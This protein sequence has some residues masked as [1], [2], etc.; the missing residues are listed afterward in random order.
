MIAILDRTGAFTHY[1]VEMLRTWGVTDVLLVNEVP[2][3]GTAKVFIVPASQQVDAQAVTAFASQ[4]GVVIAI[5]PDEAL[6]TVAGLRLGGARQ[7]PGHVRFSGI[8][9]GGFSGELVPIVSAANVYETEHA[10]PPLAYLCDRAKFGGES[11]AV[12]QRSVGEGSVVTIAFDLPRCVMLLRQGDPARREFVPEGDGC[13]R[14]S[15]MAC[16]KAVGDAGWT[17]YADLLARMLVEI[18]RRQLPGPTPLLWHLPAGAPSLLLYSGD[19]DHAPI[20]DNDEQM[21]TLQSHGGRMDLYII[22]DLTHSTAAD[23]ARYSLHHDLGPHPNLRPLDG[24]PVAERL[25]GLRRQI[26]LFKTTFGLQPLSVRN[27]CTAWAGYM[28][29]VEVLEECG[30]RMEGSYFSSDYM[31]GR[32]YAPY[33]SFGG[34]MP[35]R[36]CRPNG[37]ILN[38]YQQHT[39]WS[40]DVLFAPDAGVYKK[41]TYSYRFSPEVFGVMVDRLLRDAA[42][43]FATPVAVCIH[44]SNRPKFSRPHDLLM[45]QAANRIGMPIW[46][47]TQWCRF[48]MGR[49]QC[50]LTNI[51]WHA[52][53]LEF[54]VTN[55]ADRDD[56]CM[57]IPLHHRAWHMVELLVAGRPVAISPTTVHREQ[58]ALVPMPR[59]ESKVRVV[60]REYQ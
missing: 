41:T 51:R 10:Q 23:V 48:W 60:Y 27:H 5:M 58:V 57:A 55:D 4:G 28:E 29:H 1:L 49:E 18:I 35:M 7:M 43:R 15:H 19:E 54:D 39:H 30:L 11:S 52:G 24:K 14:P 2:A 17:P 16:E 31:Q 12:T 36:F 45:L 56:V 20:E 32:E 25:Q 3:P 34:A 9:P 21:V 22:P 46:S 38:V 59:G 26:D 13:A 33:H 6:A 53:E 47:F 44:P 8:L 37:T 50:R 40:D 42:E